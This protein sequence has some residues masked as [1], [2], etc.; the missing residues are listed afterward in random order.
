LNRQRHY[1]TSLAALKL[2]P[3]RRD[4]K[5][6]R[7]DV[8]EREIGPARRRLHQFGDLVHARVAPAG[9]RQMPMEVLDPELQEP[10]SGQVER[11]RAKLGQA[12]R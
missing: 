1:R 7:D 9:G 8:D 11:L 2:V 12:G 5:R 6:D 3:Y 4:R 10:A